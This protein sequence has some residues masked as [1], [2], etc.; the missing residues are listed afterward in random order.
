[1]W[2]VLV[3]IH[4]WPRVSLLTLSFDLPSRNS[5]T[6]FAMDG[7]EGASFPPENY[8]DRSA[9]PSSSSSEL[10]SLIR[11]LTANVNKLASVMNNPSPAKRCRSTKD[12]PDRNSDLEDSSKV[13]PFLFGLGFKK[14]AKKRSKAVTCI[15][16]GQTDNECLLSQYICKSHSCIYDESCK[17]Y[18]GI[19]AGVRLGKILV[20]NE[21]AC[22]EVLSASPTGGLKIL[23]CNWAFGTPGY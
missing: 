5:Y 8:H 19:N 9:G 2:S 21:P 14:K 4:T 16:E 20:S 15:R 22:H 18:S 12:E 13:T 1:M 10:A 17:R 23:L 3:S 6:S 11:A 7:H